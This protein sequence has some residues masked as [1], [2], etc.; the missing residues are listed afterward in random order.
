MKKKMLLSWGGILL[1]LLVGVSFCWLKIQCSYKDAGFKHVKKLQSMANLLITGNGKTVNE[2]SSEDMI[3]ANVNVETGDRFSKITTLASNYTTPIAVEPNNSKF[4]VGT[5]F[6]IYEFSGETLSLKK[7]VP[8]DEFGF[9]RKSC[10]L[11]SFLV[12]FNDYLCFAITQNNSNFIIKWNEIKPYKEFL[13]TDL[14]FSG[15]YRIARVKDII[16][17]PYGSSGKLRK[18]P[19]IYFSPEPKLLPFDCGTK[20]IPSSRLNKYEFIDYSP[21]YG[22]LLSS[23]IFNNKNNDLN[24]LIMINKDKKPRKMCYGI[25]AIWGFDGYIYFIRGERELWRIHQR[26][27]EKELVFI[28]P[29]S[30]LKD[31]PLITPMVSNDRKLLVH[32]YIIMS[33]TRKNTR[34]STH[35]IIVFDLLRKEYR[36]ITT[37]GIIN[38]YQWLTPTPKPSTE[39]KQPT[40]K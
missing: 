37:R 2:Y 21:E 23:R 13:R 40:A 14:S 17:S 4:F 25:R 30:T 18:C 39:P 9:S 33:K 5:R 8:L 28:P 35:K 36:I 29:A 27:R 38:Q 24:Y 15:N 11:A 16:N 3:I 31:Y 1:F 7:V 22:W 32:E 20:N 26:T 10:S 19:Y 34:A 6:S 12:S